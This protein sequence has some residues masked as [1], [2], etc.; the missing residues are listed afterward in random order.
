ME[1][2]VIQLQI[3][4]CTRPRSGDYPGLGPCELFSAEDGKFG[5]R[6]KAF[7]GLSHLWTTLLLPDEVQSV[8]ELP[9]EKVQELAKTNAFAKGK[10]FGGG[11]I[12]FA[13]CFLYAIKLAISGANFSVV[14]AWVAISIIPAML[15]SWVLG[16]VCGSIAQS[17]SK[18][19]NGKC[20]RLEYVNEQNAVVELVVN[21]TDAAVDLLMSRSRRASHSIP[22][23]SH[24]DEPRDRSHETRLRQ[25]D[26]LRT[27]NLISEEEFRL[28]REEIL[29]SV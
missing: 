11:K 12:I 20:C 10:T 24:A 27:A 18:P 5:V 19:L 21:G 1:N 14:A 16:T 7:S 3:I 6:W 22:V 28:K 25:L 4:Q 29:K 26:S 23:S 2:N 9:E 13:I 15:I 8:L 17:F